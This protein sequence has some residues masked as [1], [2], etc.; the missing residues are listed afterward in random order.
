MRELNWSMLA[1]DIVS[2]PASRGDTE[3][4]AT[5]G[6]STEPNPAG[7]DARNPNSLPRER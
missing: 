1:R 3:P 5:R 7:A 4:D 2:D 6:L